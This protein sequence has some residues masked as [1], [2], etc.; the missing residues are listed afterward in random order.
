MTRLHVPQAVDDGIA[1][2][3]AETQPTTAG[4]A[5]ARLEI[6]IAMD[7]IETGQEE[8][9]AAVQRFVAHRRFQRVL[10]DLYALPELQA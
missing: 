4:V 9:A 7:R 1:A 10:D 2:A 5:R 3:I 8:R 6:I